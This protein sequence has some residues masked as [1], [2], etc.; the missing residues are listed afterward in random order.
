MNE[1][2][3]NLPNSLKLLIEGYSRRVQKK[4]LLDDIVNFNTS[5]KELLKTAQKIINKE[6][7]RDHLSV[8]T[9]RLNEYTILLKN[10]IYLCKL[11]HEKCYLSLVYRKDTSEKQLVRLFW[12]SQSE[13]ERAE[14][15]LLLEKNVLMRRNRPSDRMYYG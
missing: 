6:Y 2:I 5:I 13:S 14:I 7:Q 1:L 8:I 9:D 15:C 10:L 11:E 4:E 3:L 12:G